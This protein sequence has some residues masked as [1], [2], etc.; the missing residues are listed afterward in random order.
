[1]PLSMAMTRSPRGMASARMASAMCATDSAARMRGMRAGPVRRGCRRPSRSSP[2]S[3]VRF[4]GGGHGA[5]VK[6]HAHGTAAFT[7][8]PSAATRPRSPRAAAAPQIF[9]AST[10]APPPRRPACTGC[11]APPRRR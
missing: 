4:A 1:M 6:G 9:S 5:E 2:S 8:R 7:L 3:N 10:V 11:L